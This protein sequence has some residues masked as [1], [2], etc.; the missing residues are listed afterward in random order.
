MVERKG[1]IFFLKLIICALNTEKYLCVFY[2][3]MAEW[4]KAAVLKTVVR[5]AYRGFES[6]IL[7]HVGDVG[8]W[9]K[10]APC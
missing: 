10:P 7:R 8:E 9:L 2:G 6:L 4:S 1:F 3:E 5:S